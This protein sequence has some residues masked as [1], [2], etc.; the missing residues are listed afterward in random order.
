[1]KQL[2]PLDANF[3]YLE[4]PHQPMIIGSLWLCDQS[5]APN[6][7][8]RHKEILQYIGDRL[9]TTSI[10]RRRLVHAPLRLDDPYWLE[11]ENF[12][13]E[14]HVRHV[15]LPQPGDWRQL[16]IFTARTMSRSIDMERAPWEIYIIEGLNNVPGVPPNSFAV[17]LRFHHAY[18]DGRSSFELSVALMEDTPD[19]DYGRRDNVQ[20]VERAPT[21][22][23]MWLRTT[24]RLIGQS[25]R[26]I[27]AGFD[28]AAKSWELFNRLQGDAKPEQ[29]VVPKT[30]FNTTV[31][32]HRSYGGHV[33]TLA[34]LK[35]VRRLCSGATVNDVIV[36]I[37]A[38]GMR[39]YLQQHNALPDE[40]SLIAMCPVAMRPDDAT[41]EGGN[42][43]SA[44]YIPIGTDIADPIERLQAVRRRTATGIPL[45]KEVLCDLGNAAGEL[46]PAYLRAA[47]AWLQSKTRL[48]S[49]I[50]LINTVITNVPGIPGT[51][52]KYFAGATICSVYPLVPISDGT[53]ISHGITGIYENLNL[54]VLADRKVVPDMDF[55]IACMEASTQEYLELAARYEAAAAAPA[56]VD[57]APQPQPAEQSAEAAPAKR[58][59]GKRG[60]PAR[61]EDEVVA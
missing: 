57:S 12:D 54:G 50:P 25:V 49:K 39:R 59:A 56:Q 6:G 47:G 30:I 37:I 9:S 31:T 2:T 27:R 51:A 34:D 11:D 18:V 14:Y 45:A 36:A 33:W 13:L 48:L 35:R 15:G 22:A 58:P 28:F 43:I 20:Y 52:R 10:F 46:I 41:Y 16:C 26:G 29:T 19:H 55:Y 24:P 21:L 8:V 4:T 17:L 53:A 7:I 42:V 40:G 1:M 32:P 61:T 44:M 23:E 5:S 38:G 60:Q 3:F